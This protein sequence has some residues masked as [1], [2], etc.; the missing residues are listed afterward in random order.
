MFSRL[1]CAP[2]GA[3]RDMFMSAAGSGT[4]DL[5]YGNTLTPMEALEQRLAS[6]R[7]ERAAYRAIRE[8]FARTPAATPDC[9]PQPPAG[10]QETDVGP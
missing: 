4:L 5:L 3:F 8:Q 2:L 10:R 9:A 1:F 7:A 6:E